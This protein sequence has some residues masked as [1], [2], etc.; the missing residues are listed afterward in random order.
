MKTIEQNIRIKLEFQRNMIRVAEEADAGH[1]LGGKHMIGGIV[2]Y[3]RT[4]I[5]IVLIGSCLTL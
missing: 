4:Y 2:F 1:T 5:V 3:K